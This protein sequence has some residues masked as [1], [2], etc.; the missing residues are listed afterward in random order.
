VL[1]DRVIPEEQLAV[2]EQVH[3]EQRGR[4]VHPHGRLGLLDQAQLAQL[5]HGVNNRHAVPLD[6]P[7]H[8]RPDGRIIAGLVTGSGWQ[9]D[10]VRHVGHE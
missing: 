10:R 3:L 2:V 9:C 1:N 6:Q 5:G 4:P 8:A 7:C